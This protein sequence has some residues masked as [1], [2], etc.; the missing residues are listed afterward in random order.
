LLWTG[1]KRSNGEIPC[2]YF[3]L[4]HEKQ[5]KDFRAGLTK[6]LLET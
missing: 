3:F 5:I 6:A 1:E 2:W 4:S